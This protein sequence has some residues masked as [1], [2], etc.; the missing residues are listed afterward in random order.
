MIQI[1]YLDSE[2]VGNKAPACLE[3]L[4]IQKRHRNVLRRYQRALSIWHN[5]MGAVCL[6]TFINFEYQLGDRC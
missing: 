1:L 6:R 3:I 2:L 4:L 5:A